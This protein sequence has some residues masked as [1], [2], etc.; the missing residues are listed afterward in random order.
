MS[1]GN[2]ILNRVYG[3]SI[4]IYVGSEKIKITRYEGDRLGVRADQSV[5]IL[6]EE[7]DTNK[8]D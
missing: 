2:L 8:N 3:Q 5:T 1:K 7:I 4:N 6:R